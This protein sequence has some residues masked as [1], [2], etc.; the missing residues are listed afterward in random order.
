[1][2]LILVFLV[3]LLAHCRLIFLTFAAPLMITEDLDSGRQLGR[4]SVQIRGLPY[5]IS[6]PSP[7][8][9][10]SSSPY[11]ASAD[12]SHS[13]P[14]TQNLAPLRSQQVHPQPQRLRGPPRNR[15]PL[16]PLYPAPSLSLL[17]PLQ[18]FFP[19]AE[20]ATDP[21]NLTT[22]N[23][24]IAVQSYLHRLPQFCDRRMMF[25]NQYLSFERGMVHFKAVD[26]HYG[27]YCNPSCDGTA[28][29]VNINGSIHHNGHL[30][31]NGT[32][33]IEFL[34]FADVLNFEPPPSRDSGRRH[35]G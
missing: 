29:S 24:I 12:S 3:T 21:H 31:F 35:R 2:R 14:S 25:R 34:T 23:A 9:S 20:G 8:S 4:G 22:R 1:M 26:Y 10:S 5:F 33:P 15:R 13:E 18:I 6:P 32:E 19:Q 27:G 11:P 30:A 16:R 17:P 7:L 28:Y